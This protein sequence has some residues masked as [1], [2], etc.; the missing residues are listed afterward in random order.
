MRRLTIFLCLAILGCAASSALARGNASDLPRLPDNDVVA[1]PLKAGTTFG[2]TRFPIP[3]RVTTPDG[4]WFGGQGRMDFPAR[5]YHYGWLELLQSP[6]AQPLGMISMIASRN[7]TRSVAATVAQLRAGASTATYNATK[8]VRLAGFAGREF[9]GQVVGT[10]HVFVP[11]TPFRP[12]AA[13]F[14]PDAYKF[15][16]GEVFRIVVLDVRDKTVVLLLEN[17]ALPADQF[18]A[19]LAAANRLLGSLRFPTAEG[20]R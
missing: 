19:F 18:P 16:H 8:P 5:D 14:Y 2:A 15:D 1:R 17:L 4:T 12:G 13:A 10:S 11:F 6:P 7:P 9:D 20:A 3:V